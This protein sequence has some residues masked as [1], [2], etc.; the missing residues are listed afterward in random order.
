MK[1]GMRKI[2]AVLTMLALVLSLG[3]ALAERQPIVSKP[4]R[5]PAVQPKATAEPEP[6]VEPTVEPTAKPTAEPT[7]EPTEEPAAEPTA[8]LPAER[9]VDFTFVWD[10][11][12]LNYG[13]VVTLVPELTGYEGFAYE[14]VWQYSTDNAVWADYAVGET[15]QYVLTEENAEWY[16]HVVVN[17]IGADAP[18]EEPAA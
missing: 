2:L 6:T 11:E 18:A 5:I 17:V 9:S 7:A 12:A 8:E 15:V 16:W 1:Q 10:G 3:S 14:L 4:F 13:D